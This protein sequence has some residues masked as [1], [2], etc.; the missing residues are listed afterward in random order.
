MTVEPKGFRANQRWL[1]GRTI[2]GRDARYG[3][4]CA[5]GS[6]HSLFR[7]D[8]GPAGFL[9]MPLL[10]WVLMLLVLVR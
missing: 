4:R 3:F 2:V 5:A 10:L 7:L 8:L 9:L 1:L 6:R